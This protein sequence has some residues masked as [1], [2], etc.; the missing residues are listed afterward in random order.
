[1][2]YNYGWNQQYY[3]SNMPYNYGWNQSYGWGDS[4]YGWN[5]PYAY[6][7]YG[8]PLFAFLIPSISKPAKPVI[9]LDPPKQPKNLQIN[10][11]TDSS[12]SLIWEDRSDD[13]DGFRI[14]RKQGA[15]GAWVELT[16]GVCTMP[17]ECPSGCTCYNNE[18]CLVSA[19][20]TTFTDSTVSS[21]QTYYYRVCAYKD[22][23]GNSGYSNESD[24]VI[25]G[26]HQAVRHAFVANAEAGL[27]IL[28]VSNPE[29]PTLKG[30]YDNAGDAGGVFVA[31]NYAYVGTGSPDSPDRIDIIDV[32][33]PAN[34][35]LKGYY[36]MPDRGCGVDV[37]GNYAYATGYTEG[38]LQI[39]DV[40][41]PAS[42]VFVGWYDTPGNA[43]KEVEVHNDYAYVSDS[44]AGLQIIDVS[45]PASPTLIGNY[46]TPSY[47]IKL[48]VRG[49]YIYLDDFNSGF[50]VLDISNPVS[51]S[52]VYSY[53]IGQ[54]QGIDVVGDYAY[55]PFYNHSLEIFDVSDPLSIEHINSF[56]HPYRP[57]YIDVFEDYAYTGDG[58]DK[59]VTVIDVSNPASPTLKASYLTTSWV[60]SVFVKYCLLPINIEPPINIKPPENLQVSHVTS[61]SVSLIWEDRS[62][63]E[64]Q[65]RIERKTGDSGDWAVIDT[66]GQNITTYVDI[67][68]VGSP[69]EYGEFYYY[70]VS[71]DTS[72]Y[73]NFTEVVAPGT[74]QA[75]RYAFV[76]NYTA[77]LTILDVSNPEDPIF[78]GSYNNGGTV[79]RVF[80]AG[81]YAYV[82]TS[83]PNRL[84]IVDV[85]DPANPRLEGYYNMPDVAWGVEVVGDYAYVDSGAAGGL[86]IIDV[87]NPA[88][89]VFVGWYDTPGNAFKELDVLNNYA[90][91]PD[92]EAGLQII[93]VSN[94]DSPTLIGSY[95]TPSE[96]HKLF[97]RGNYAYLDDY[98]SGFHVLDISNPASPSEVYS[99]DI[100]QSQG[101]DV[102]GDY[103]Y[104]PFYYHRL[105]I[106]DVSNPLSIQPINSLYHPYRPCSIDVFENYVYTGDGYDKRVTVID[107]SNPASPTVKVSY[108]TTSW[109]WSVFV[110]YCLLPINIEP[111]INIKPPKNLQVSN[112][113][114]DSVSLIWEDRS[115][116]SL[117]EDGFR[118]ERRLGAEGAWTELTGGDCSITGVCPSGC[119]C[120]NNE[121]CLVSA[122]STTFTDSTVSSGQTYYYRVCAYKDGHGNSS[123][124][125]ES[126]A[127]IPGQHQAVLYA[128]VADRGN[129]LQIVDVSDPS[130][131]KLVGGCDTPGDTLGVYV[132]GNYAYVT[133]GS[134]GGLRIIDISDP[135]NP[136]F[137]GWYDTPGTTTARRL[138]VVDNLVYVPDGASGLQ[139]INVSDPANP[140]LA[141][142]WTLNG[143]AGV[144]VIDNYAYLAAGGRLDILDISNPAAPNLVGGWE[145]SPNGPTCIYVVGDYAYVGAPYSGFDGN[146][147][148]INIS[149]PLNPALVSKFDTP[150]WD[151]MIKVVGNYAYDADD[152]NGQLRIIDVSDPEN[153]A[154]V[155]VFPY[156]AEG[157]DIIGDY[158]Y[159]AHGTLV[160]VDISNPENPTLVKDFDTSGGTKSVFVKYCLIS[161][162]AYAP[163]NLWAVQAAPPNKDRIHV[164]W[165]DNSNNEDG[166][167]IERK[168]YTDANYS[169]LNEVGQAVT[170]YYDSSVTAGITYCYRVRAYQGAVD[171]SYSNEA[172]GAVMI[173]PPDSL[174]VVAATY[175]GGSLDDWG[176]GIDLDYNGNVYIAG[177]TLSG[178]FPTTADAYDP[179]HNGL[180][181]NFI[182]RLSPGLDAL[183]YS[184]FLGGSG[185]EA[186]S[187]TLDSKANTVIKVTSSGIYLSSTTT[188][189]D[190]PTTEGAFDPE[191]GPRVHYALTICKFSFDG[192]T[193]L[194]G[195]YLHG[196]YPTCCAYGTK[197][198][199]LFVDPLGY[200]YLGLASEPN[201]S[202]FPTTEG[203]YDRTWNGGYWDGIALKFLPAGNESSD[204]IY[205]SYVGSTGRDK[206]TGMAVTPSGDVYYVGSTQSSG[207]PVTVGGYDIF[208]NSPGVYDGI[209][210][211]MRF[212]GAGSAD[213]I[214]S[215]FIGTEGID[216]M[217]K[218]TVD[219]LNNVYFIGRTDSASFPVIAGSFDETYN[220]GDR[221]VVIC[222]MTLAKAGEADLIYSSFIGGSGEENA[223]MNATDIAVDGS[224]YVY[225]TG[226]TNSP[227]FPVTTGAVYHGGYDIFFCKLDLSKNGPADLI[228][229]TLIGGSGDD[230][231]TEMIIAPDGDIYLSG[232]TTSTDFPVTDG[233]Y[234]TQ[235]TGSDLDW[236]IV[237]MGG[238]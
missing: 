108:L 59:R 123:Y 93:D 206:F 56:S 44:E 187:Y 176:P 184:T 79:G 111:P 116:D 207:Y 194:Y 162:V 55:V 14:E 17:G 191:F 34:P 152:N 84:D 15:E 102:V 205:S 65:F 19:N 85:S 183:G 115:G 150:D 229:S 100:G 145:V 64:T 75:V 88:S 146:F 78:K 189:A 105:V 234:D 201:Y 232:Q 147:Y 197:P 181:D 47:L 166:F 129:G 179:S 211:K 28:D 11:V 164:T 20:N 217:I 87:S 131:P 9:T 30:S 61:N 140:V 70:R 127:V 161:G 218:I 90:Y 219:A 80:V 204:L 41:N 107:V 237:K 141:G 3:G 98:N 40:S 154:L 68:D 225:I 143:V 171:S 126:D 121:E 96:L 97:I 4:Y 169:Y 178:D 67:D 233:A 213:L 156:Q 159:L 223:N 138:E 186:G 49:N 81:N 25:P 236:F 91:V 29:N 118:V 177:G 106:F 66:V 74:Q 215:S 133:D 54:S 43:F 226:N 33:D 216:D 202:Y 155:S 174:Q 58:Y 109:V 193:M 1:M 212:N 69:V 5:Q 21:G 6:Y 180:G 209:I 53:D 119:T 149:D 57:C 76:A 122:N 101:I 10:H 117:A 135:T 142:A 199:E 151:N 228:Y 48:F 235:K 60:W 62:D 113:T 42:P 36:N 82:C 24:P 18:E 144:D 182:A 8:L 52:E 35:R 103:A 22:G 158:L 214:Y 112:V 139:I 200:C 37:V 7:N 160:I 198:N 39:I 13:E 192:K 175:L 220:G 99:Y 173:D 114:S 170:E 221:D 185:H 94:P 31:G 72:D 238:G 104:V 132:K 222:K 165:Q 196:T 95:D 27:T 32:S 167:R 63:N 46:D 92:C 86:Q 124:S 71:A 73:S 148:I 45:N 227:D 125:N 168:E 210:T 231:P 195:T 134:V 110:K 89:P 163:S 136:V 23:N 26:Q 120:Y 137:T 203:A 190:F 50:H 157:L 153:P 16:G 224:G 83:S 128:F 2:P 130:Q 230:C 172:C 12:V 38:G 77:G 208:H 51:P 188:S